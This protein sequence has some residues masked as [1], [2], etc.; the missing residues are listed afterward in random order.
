MTFLFCRGN[1]I[2]PWLVYFA[3]NFLFCCGCFVLPLFLL[4]HGFLFCRGF[5]VSPWLFGFAVTL[6]GHRN[7]QFHMQFIS[8]NSQN[9]NSQLINLTGVAQISEIR[10]NQGLFKHKSKFLTVYKTEF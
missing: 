10:E 1:F 2:L 6:M 5:L 9:I 8:F 7:D 4:C 3:V